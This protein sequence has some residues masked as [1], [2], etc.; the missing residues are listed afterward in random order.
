MTQIFIRVLIFIVEVNDVLPS[1]SLGV[2]PHVCTLVFVVPLIQNLIH[3]LVFSFDNVSSI[4]GHFELFLHL[5][6]DYNTIFFFLT[7]WLNLALNISAFPSSLDLTK[8]GEALPECQVADWVEFSD[9]FLSQLNLFERKWC[10][11]NG[12]CLL[13]HFLPVLIDI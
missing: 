5:L 9:S 8:E 2:F 6:G 1:D 3:S 10:S 11:D 12:F 7:L 13:C 4:L